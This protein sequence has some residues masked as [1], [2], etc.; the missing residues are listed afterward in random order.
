LL[1]DRLDHRSVSMSETGH[2]RPTR[3]IEIP[4]PGAINEIR[5]FA[6]H[7]DRRVRARTAMEDVAHVIG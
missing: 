3:S 7:R 5:P 6:A 2:G 1:L 4:P